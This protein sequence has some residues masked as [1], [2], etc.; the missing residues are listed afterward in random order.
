MLEFTNVDSWPLRIEDYKYNWEIF[1][2]LPVTAQMVRETYDNLLLRMQNKATHIF[3]KN[4]I[5]KH[6]I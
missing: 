1:K 6:Y 4:T 5:K 3:S 2:K